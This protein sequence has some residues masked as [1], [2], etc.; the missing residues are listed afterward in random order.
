MQT[1]PQTIVGIEST[2][3][4]LPRRRVRKGVALGLEIFPGGG[5]QPGPKGLDI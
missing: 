1:E 3:P 5:V 2:S 4:G